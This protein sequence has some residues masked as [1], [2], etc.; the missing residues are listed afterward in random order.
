[1]EKKKYRLVTRSDLDGLVSAT[2][3]K[4]LDLIDEIKFV[5][6]KDVQDG[7]VEITENDI[8]T[9]IP[10]NKNA[11]ISFDHHHSELERLGE[12]PP[13]YILDVKAP[14]AAQVVYEYYGG[15]ETFHDIIPDMMDGVNQADSAQFDLEDVLNPKGWALLSFLTDPRTGLGRFREFRIS[16][17][18]LMMDLIDI[19]LVEKSIDAVLENPDVKERVEM[20]QDYEEKAKDQIKRLST[21]YGKTVVFDPRNEEN[22][23]PTNRFMIYAL[24][25]EA[26]VSIHAMW[27]LKKQNTVFAV[28]KSIFNRSSRADIGSI[29]LKHGGGGH[30]PAGTCQVVNEEAEIK[31]KEIVE[32][33]NAA[34]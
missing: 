12:L 10:Y 11:Y 31:I 18:N 1:M 9:N 29:M 5:H 34:G 32:A 23:Y 15:E 24:F 13:N 16:N 14:S 33:I 25:P 26:T 17:Y 3:L 4:K 22:I 19:C 27:G 20:Y 8:T 2:L 7:I 30:I 28:G 6:P 21:V